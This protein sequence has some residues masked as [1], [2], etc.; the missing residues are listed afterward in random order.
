MGGSICENYWGIPAVRVRTR[1]RIKYKERASYRPLSSSFTPFLFPS[2]LPSLFSSCT[3]AWQ[4]NNKIFDVT[5]GNIELEVNKVNVEEG[6]VGG[7]FV[8]TQFSDTDMGSK[9]PKKLL[10]KGIFY[11]RVAQ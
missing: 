9:A 10:M 4:E 1:S 11:G 8:S 3:A 2:L 7:V 5:S 6:E